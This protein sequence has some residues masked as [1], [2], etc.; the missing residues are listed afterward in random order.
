M[1]TNIVY[2]V[3]DDDS[4]C[5]SLKMFLGSTGFVARSFTSG[6]AF[7]YEAGQLA[8]GCVLLDVR[9]PDLDGLSVLSRLAE[10]KE[11]LA[12]IVM[13]GHGDVATAVKAMKSG[14][15]DFLE[16]PFEEDLLRRALDRAKEALTYRLYQADRKRTAVSQ[17][18]TLTSRERD[19]LQGVIHG[20]ANKVLAH[21]LSI[22]VRTVEM[23]R[24]SLMGRLG[25][26]S[27]AEV[28]RLAFDAGLIDRRTSHLRDERVRSR[29]VG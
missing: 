24:A 14:A 11:R 18:E 17:L 23:H 19:V 25:A 9:M 7:V 12:V 8:P 26:R 22:S 5:Q 16:K 15:V 27:T 29:A 1:H 3:D 13:T 10:A 21:K 6:L 2:V 4:V 20:E 28:I